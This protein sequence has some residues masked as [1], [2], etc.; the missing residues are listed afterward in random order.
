MA[1]KI[2]PE[3]KGKFNSK[4]DSK[5]GYKSKSDSRSNSKTR[6]NDRT[7]SRTHSPKSH[8]FDKGYQNGEQ[9]EGIHAV[10]SL[11]N[12][13]RKVKELLIDKSK[14][15]S[16]HQNL[17]GLATKK[18][19]SI[20]YVDANYLRD[21]AQSFAPQGV[22]AFAEPINFAS[23][24]ALLKKKLI[25][26]CDGITDPQNLGSVIRTA[27]CVGAGVVFPK[28]RS[29]SL[30]A[31]VLKASAGAGEIVPLLRCS[32]LGNWLT[33]MKKQGVVIVGCDHPSDFSVFDFSTE[34]FD[35]FNQVVVVL[36]AEGM[37]L[38]QSIKAK[39]DYIV[40][41]P[42]NAEALSGGIDSLNV[43]VVCG[44]VTYQV[45]RVLTKD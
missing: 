37:G 41:I 43:S 9:V 23:Q 10:Y 21:L 2:R 27:S 44:I 29:A 1:K 12:N 30:T 26:A 38:S 17:A 5:S 32:G 45:A 20:R 34:F 7:N 35:K 28:Q 39:C 15:G 8:S 36:G 6:S 13:G 4:S 3:K 24:D 25:I 42:M 19:I 31:T 14:S 22:I 11:L 40:H 18:G 16:D 33:N